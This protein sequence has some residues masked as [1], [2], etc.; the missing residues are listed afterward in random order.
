MADGVYF[1]D[2]GPEFMR[3]GNSV[4]EVA[5]RKT[6]GAIASITDKV[7]GGRVSEGSRHE[8]LWGAYQEGGSYVGGCHY[9]NTRRTASAT[10]GR[11]PRIP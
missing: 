1:D 9:S 5:F 6:N 2:T 7:N 4:Y 10:P 11:P 3:L 8:C